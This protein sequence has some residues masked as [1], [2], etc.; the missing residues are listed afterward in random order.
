M[1]PLDTVDKIVYQRFLAN[2]M[3]PEELLQCFSP[4]IICI[5]YPELNEAEFPAL[6]VLER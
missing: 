4:Q 3:S 1:N 5:S 6:E 2:M